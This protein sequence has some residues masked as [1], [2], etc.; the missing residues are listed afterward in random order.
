MKAAN[1][2]LSDSNLLFSIHTFTVYI[3]SQNLTDLKEKFR[4]SYRKSDTVVA[5]G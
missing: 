5:G 3:E 4:N 1:L 2:F